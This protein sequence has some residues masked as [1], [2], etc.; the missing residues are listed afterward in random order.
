MNLLRIVNQIRSD[1]SQ[2]NEEDEG[3]NDVILESHLSLK[4]QRFKSKIKEM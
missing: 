4:T 1:S 3:K 2:I